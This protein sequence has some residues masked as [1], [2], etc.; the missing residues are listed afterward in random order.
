[1]IY[2]KLW[3]VIWSEIRAWNLCCL[4]SLYVYEEVSIFFFYEGAVDKRLHCTWLYRDAYHTNTYTSCITISLITMGG[5][6]KSGFSGVR[7]G[8]PVASSLLLLSRS[9]WELLFIVI[10]SGYRQSRL[11]PTSAY[12]S[13][14]CVIIVYAPFIF[15]IF[16]N[17]GIAIC[18]IPMTMLGLK[19]KSNDTDFSG[20]CLFVCLSIRK[21]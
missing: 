17:S 8:L 5:T 12:R 6:Q 13:R 3:N 2:C 21:W 19:Q 16:C 11:T 4:D 10:S 14:A 18:L 15:R 9:L 1:M 20:F 7:A